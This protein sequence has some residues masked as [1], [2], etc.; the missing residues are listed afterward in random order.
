M[1]PLTNHAITERRTMPDFA[2]QMQWLVDI[3]YPDAPVTR[4]V[5][6]NLVSSTGQALNTHR[7]ASLYQTFPAAVARCIAKRL[8]FHNTP[9]HGSWLNM[10][11]I[12]FSVFSRSCLRRRLPDV[13]ALCRVVQ[14]LEIA[15]NEAQARINWRFG[16]QDARP[17]SID[18]IPSRPS[19]TEH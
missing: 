2:R 6:D 14:A 7:K 3:A 10:A 13:E 16:I 12:E 9:K 5:L 18:Y 17:S 8:E 19:L 11:E 15:R 1:R 4:V